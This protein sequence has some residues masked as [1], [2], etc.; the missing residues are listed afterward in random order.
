VAGPA[1]VPAGRELLGLLVVAAPVLGE[2]GADLAGLRE[3]RRLADVARAGRGEGPVTAGE[4]EGMFRR[5]WEWPA[6]EPVTAGELRELAAV[7]GR[8]AGCGGAGQS[9]P[10]ERG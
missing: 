3:L 6:D 5:V 7:M 9:W 1:G 4:L 8:P 10:G 2:R